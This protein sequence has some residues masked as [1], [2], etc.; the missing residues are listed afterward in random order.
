L[1]SGTDDAEVNRVWGYDST[2]AA[3]GRSTNSRLVLKFNTAVDISDALA[4]IYVPTNEEVSDTANITNV[5]RV[6]DALPALSAAAFSATARIAGEVSQV[7]SDGDGSFTGGAGTND[8]NNVVVELPDYETALGVNIASTDKLVI[9]NIV[10]DGVHYSVHINAPAISN[11]ASTSTETSG[12]TYTVYRHVH[13]GVANEVDGIVVGTSFTTAAPSFSGQLQYHEEIDTASVSVAFSGTG[14]VDDDTTNFTGVGGTVTTTTSDEVVAL[15]TTSA[16]A[17]NNTISYTL[18]A[19]SAGSVA[20]GVNKVVGRNS[21]LTVTASDFSGNQT[22][23]VITLMKGH[24]RVAVDLSGAG[25]DE[26]E[27]VLLNTISGDAVN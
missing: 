13:L 12:L 23:A 27:K 10:V 1:A 24:G 17:T 7:D 8:E 11:A 9:Q 6:T 3:N 21:T 25:A 20:E 16:S 22:T 14:A 4:F 15:S 2:T 5:V 18:D 26:N 19:L